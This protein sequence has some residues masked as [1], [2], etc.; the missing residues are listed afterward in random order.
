MLFFREDFLFRKLVVLSRTLFIFH[1]VYL[2]E[3]CLDLQMAII[4][5]KLFK[6]IKIF[7]DNKGCASGNRNHL[8]YDMCELWGTGKNTL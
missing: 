8:Y 4:T 6:L 7:G 3:H 2:Y 1:T 5:V